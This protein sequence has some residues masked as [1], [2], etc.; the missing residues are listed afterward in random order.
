[1]SQK[2]IRSLE[3][4]I[5]LLFLFS[6]DRPALDHR[7]IATRLG[8]SLSTTYRFLATL[9]GKRMVCRDPSGRYTLDPRILQLQAVARGNLDVVQI[10]R[11]HLERLASLSGET[12]Q[13]FL[14][15]G[16]EVVCT[17]SVAGP[18][19][20]RIMPDKGKGIPLH[21]SALGRVVLAFQQSSV[22]ERY[23]RERGLTPMTPHTVT[24]VPRF[25]AILR[26]IRRNGYAISHQQ[27]YVGARGVAAPIADHRG[28]VIGS[29]GVS[30]FDR[31]FAH[32]DACAL[33]APLLESARQVSLGLGANAEAIQPRRC[34]R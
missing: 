29:L 2:P 22:V 26:Q 25:R 17:E 31:R 18:H 30:G 12:A 23:L 6:P 10:A 1:M 9:R 5:D 20:V 28:A 14:L 15:D 34:T 8:I 3:R 33:V 19:A 32:R 11:P 27:M 13:L 21:A 16:N 7:E 4:G 24:D